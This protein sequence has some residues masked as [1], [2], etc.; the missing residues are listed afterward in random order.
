MQKNV[1]PTIISDLRD[2]IQRLDG[3]AARAK[4]V[5]PFGLARVDDHLPGG[6]LSFG[7]LHEVSGGGNG[8]VDGAAAALF[9]AGIAARSKG[10]ILW[11]LTRQDLFAPAL[12]QAGLAPG[13][14]LYAECRDV[15]NHFSSHNAL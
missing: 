15:T 1:N 11:C 13:R 7:S 2:R 3:G 4:A 9:C 6:G 10:K 8:A 5:L 14:V 12:A